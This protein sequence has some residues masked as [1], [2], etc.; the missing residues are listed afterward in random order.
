QNV[1]PEHRRVRADCDR[2]HGAVPGVARPGGGTRREEVRD[3][4]DGERL[5]EDARREQHVLPAHVAGQL[6]DDA[7]E[8]VVPF[9]TRAHADTPDR[10]AVA[11]FLCSAFIASMSRPASDSPS[12]LPPPGTPPIFAG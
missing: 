9:G 11:S 10:A 1:T 5:V 6:G 8:V 3:A 4:E 2:T 7:F 12:A